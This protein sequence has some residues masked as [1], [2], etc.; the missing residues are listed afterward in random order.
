MRLRPTGAHA[1]AKLRQETKLIDLIS[2]KLKYLTAI[3][4]NSS[5]G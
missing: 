1:T 2:I 4:A 5:G 3:L